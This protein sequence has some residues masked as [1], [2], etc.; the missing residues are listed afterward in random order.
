MQERYLGDSHDFLKYALLRHLARRLEI[1][2]G[3][4]WYLTR[5]EEVD[6]A[7]NSDGEKRH[8]LTGKGW[9]TTDADLLDRLGKFSDPALRKIN[10]VAEWGILPADTAYYPKIVSN[11]ERKAWFE[12]SISALDDAGLIFLDPDNGFEVKSMTARTSSKYALYEE[13]SAYAAMGK[14][15]VSIQFARQC[16]PLRRADE[17]RER[18]LAGS[19]GFA[20]MPVLRGR[21]APNILF[22]T[23]A[24][25]DRQAGVANA[26]RSF[27][28]TSDKVEVID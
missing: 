3:V 18:L 12:G 6:K 14:V 8:H 15:A 1:K 25:A 5:T 17:T 23:L 2:I 24:P 13:A 9:R 19:A 22:L 10:H 26:L 7:G 16:N 4:N 27:A 28:E 21:V 20:A 11:V